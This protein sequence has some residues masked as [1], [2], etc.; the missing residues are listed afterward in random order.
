MDDMRGVMVKMKQNNRWINLD[1]AIEHCK[2]R[3]RETSINNIGYEVDASDV[4]LD[5]AECRI[6]N[7]LTEIS[8]T[9]EECEDAISRKEL[10]EA[11]DTWPK[12]G[13]DERGRIVNWHEGLVP[14]VKWLD[15]FMVLS[16]SPSVMPKRPTGHWIEERD[17]EGKK[18]WLT[19]SVCGYKTD[20][21]YFNNPNYCPN[22]GANIRGA[23]K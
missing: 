1:R 12:Y 16:N 11:L 14:Y 20:D 10:A 21:Y 15:V 18:R 7:W 6:E 8:Q 5:I 17:C 13:V 2:Q 3:L 9:V 19:C 23:Q 22:C 4:F